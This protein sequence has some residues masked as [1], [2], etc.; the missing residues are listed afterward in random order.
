MSEPIT[1]RVNLMCVSINQLITQTKDNKRYCF[2]VPS[3]QRG[4]RWES[5][6]IVRLLDD[7]Y[8]FSQS[9][10]PTD[11]YCLQPIIV[12]QISQD[13]MQVRMG[14]N[15]RCKAD[16]NYYEV[17]DGQQRLTTI[18]LILK[19]VQREDTAQFFDLEYERDTK[20]NFSRKAML[21]GLRKT[22]IST[23]KTVD[24]HYFIQAYNQIKQW[25]EQKRKYDSYVDND[26]EST[27]KRNTNVIWYELSNTNTDC[28]QIF[29]NSYFLGKRSSRQ[30]I[31]T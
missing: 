22:P 28:Y 9:A 26:M 16:N 17:V 24:E 15:Y 6:Q 14:Q 23:H 12:K 13:E 27:I 11:F 29:R 30:C 18:Y 4:Y 1:E 10:Q 5:E 25:T 3:Y 21:Q 20:S 19:Y 2:L 7:L 31:W 8:E